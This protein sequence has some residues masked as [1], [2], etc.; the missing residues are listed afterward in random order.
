M[1][2]QARGDAQEDASE[3]GVLRMERGGK[4]HGTRLSTCAPSALATTEDQ[5]VSP[6]ER[7]KTKERVMRISAPLAEE[8]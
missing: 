5:H 8:L 2:I 7:T 6:G 3:G 1:E 4:I